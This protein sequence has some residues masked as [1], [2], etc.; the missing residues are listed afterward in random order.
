[1]KTKKLYD[2][3]HFFCNEL[4]YNLWAC[5]LLSKSNKTEGICENRFAAFFCSKEG[6]TL[7]QYK[8]EAIVSVATCI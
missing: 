6:T 4:Q 2:F 3:I 1:M 8:Y 7:Y 5:A